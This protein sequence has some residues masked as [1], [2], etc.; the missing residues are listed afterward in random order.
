MPPFWLVLKVNEDAVVTYFHC[1]YELARPEE[2]L[3]WKQIH[4][5][6]LDSISALAKSINQ[7]ML[8]KD[9]HDTRLCNQL[10]EPE[11]ND[12]IWHQD[13][14]AHIKSAPHRLTRPN[15]I[16]PYLTNPYGFQEQPSYLEAT[17]KL[18]PGTFQCRQVW[19]THFPLHPRLKTGPGK[20][21]TSKGVQQLRIVL[22]AFSVNNRSNMFVY[23]EDSGNVFYLRL[24]ESSCISHRNTSGRIETPPAGQMPDHLNEICDFLFFVSVRFDRFRVHLAIQYR[25]S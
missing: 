22:S 8:L 16:D 21:G 11:T 12:D 17:L 4:Q 20:L 5:D 10:L 15:E 14:M 25:R 19:E 7:Q 18:Q 3:Q 24:H 1:R 9:L 2:L 6:L 13:E 23:Q